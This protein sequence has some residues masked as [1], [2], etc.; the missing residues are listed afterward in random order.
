[1]QWSNQQEDVFEWAESGEGNLVVAAYAG[2]GKTTTM[3]EAARRA[4]EDQILV[5]AFNKRI[6]EELQTKARDSRIE[7][8]TLHSLGMSIIRQYVKS[9]R[10]SK[11]SRGPALARKVCGV[12]AP[13]E[14][15][16]LIGKACN[17]FREMA[18]LATSPSDP[19]LIDI[20][21]D[22]ELQPSEEWL[23]DGWDA[24][25]VARRGFE[26]MQLAKLP[27]TEIDFSDMI[28]LP[29]ARRWAR[30]KYPLVIVDE[31]QDMN[32]AQLL[33]SQ[34][35]CKGRIAVVGDRHQAIYGFRGADS[36][37]L[38][39]LKEA[40]G[41]IE[42]PLSIT[43]RC[44]RSVVAEAQAFVPDFTAAAEAPEGSVS[45]ISSEQLYDM[46]EIGDAVISRKNA[47][48]ISTA[49][50]LIRMGKP[51]KVIGKDIAA[52]LRAL[53]NEL[54]TGRARNSVPAMLEKLDA[55]VGRQQQRIEASTKD[56]ERAAA[57]IAAVMDKAETLA[58]VA[59]GVASVD[60]LR[61]RIERLFVA[62]TDGQVITC[63][64]VHKAK[65]LEW[66]RC[67]LLDWTFFL[68]FKPKPGERERTATELARAAEERNIRY[69]AIT[70]TQDQLFYVQ[71]Q[72][73]K[74]LPPA[75]T[76]GEAHGFVRGL[77]RS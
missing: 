63:S 20:V 15:V 46:A 51:A 9:F 18:P 64:S 25:S 6:A 61:G 23:D 39:R 19:V 75:M 77:F 47:D 35:V 13:E 44:P 12:D 14:V 74:P 40:Y 60:E 27:A 11:E 68:G 59:E 32:A 5:C 26:A 36:G 71:G 69:V 17:Y 31:A 66:P 34:M 41:A 4:P 21:L 58:A 48:L 50:R 33:L 76:K 65:G 49:L 52:S 57:R 42:L 24:A 29:V 2:T 54:A 7:A 28:F 45:S 67:F 53:M 70:R 30:P 56:V 8:R 3:L 10:I 72:S 43:Y 16:K 22:Y 62:D 37:S 38:D 1:M 55:W 73:R